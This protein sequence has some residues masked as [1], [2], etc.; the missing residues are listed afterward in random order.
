MLFDIL[1]LLWL[2]N[3]SSTKTSMF[4]KTKYKCESLNLSVTLFYLW[5]LYTNHLRYYET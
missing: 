3:V 4:N 2:N 1:K 5:G